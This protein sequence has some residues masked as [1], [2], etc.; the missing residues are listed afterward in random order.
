VIVL[1]PF[2]VVSYTVR[3]CRKRPENGVSDRLR[4]F[5]IR[6][7]TA[8]I[9]SLPNECNAIK[10]GPLRPRLIHL[11]CYSIR[12]TS[13]FLNNT[14]NWT[15]VISELCL[16]FRV[17][18]N[19]AVK[20]R[21][22]CKTAKNGVFH[23]GFTIALNTTKIGGKNDGLLLAKKRLAKGANILRWNLRQ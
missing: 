7:N 16:P 17:R 5:A 8:V 6:W 2:F 11:R 3:N 12:C 15:L 20:D 4:S 19:D 1:R 23:R 9:R 14:W 13:T 22:R 18:E 10:T 21:K